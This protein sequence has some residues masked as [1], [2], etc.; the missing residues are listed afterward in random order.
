MKFARRDAIG[1]MLT[2]L[3][4]VSSSADACS[5]A[6]PPYEGN[7]VVNRFVE[8]IARQ[9]FERMSQTLT[10]GFLFYPSLDQKVL[11]KAEFIEF[12]RKSKKPN[13]DG[14]SS[15]LVDDNGWQIVQQEFFIYENSVDSPTSCGNLGNYSRRIAIYDLYEDDS[16]EIPC[17]PHPNSTTCL[18]DTKRVIGPQI[19]RLQYI[20]LPFS[21]PEMPGTENSS[22]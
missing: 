1:A 17:P 12:I 5:I 19:F 14:I 4:S 10:D 7:K 11:D 9:D 20:A 16:I 18:R 13:K 21:R 22:D 6:T 15:K 3:A 2:G 8:L